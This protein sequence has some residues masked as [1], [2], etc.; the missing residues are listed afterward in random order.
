MQQVSF[1]DSYR[2]IRRNDKLKQRSL[3]KTSV[4]VKKTKFSFDEGGDDLNL[5]DFKNAYDYVQVVIRKGLKSD[6]SPF[7]P[8]ELENLK[9]TMT[10]AK[11]KVNLRCSIVLCMGI[12]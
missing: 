6:G 3:F 8:N 4:V 7:S 11:T 9:K 10:A 1:E 12:M 5:G 2:N